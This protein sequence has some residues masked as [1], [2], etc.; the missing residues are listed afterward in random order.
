M[1]ENPFQSEITMFTGTF[2]PKGSM[3]CHGQILNTSQHHA[4]FALLGNR[5]GG[6]GTTTF[7]LPDFRGDT[8][9]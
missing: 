6:N 2:A 4:L 9:L 5:F 1:P 7:A 3:Y 8:P